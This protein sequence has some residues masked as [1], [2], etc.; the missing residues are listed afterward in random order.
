MDQAAISLTRENGIPI[1]VFPIGN[2]GGVVG[3]VTGEGPM[4]V[5]SDKT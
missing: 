4:T 3:A 1:V 5:I 2:D